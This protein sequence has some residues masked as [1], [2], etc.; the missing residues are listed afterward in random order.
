MSNIVL[1][2]VSKSFGAT[3]VLDEL[4]LAVPDG[5]VVAVLGES[6]SGKTTLLRLVAGFERPGGGT[7]VIGDDVVDAQRLFVPPERRGIGYVAQEGALFPHLSVAKN[8]AFGLARAE[9]K[10]SRVDELLELVGMSGLGSRYPHELSGGQQQ[11]VALARALAPHPRVVLLDEPFSALDAGLRASLRAEVIQILRSTGITTVLVT[12]DQ[13]EA[14]SVSDLVGV[15]ARGKI[16]QLATPGA[17]YASPADA[18]L[19]GFLGEANLVV[20][21]ATN[22]RATT[23]FGEMELG[24]GAASL[25]GTVI[26]LI[27]P[28]QLALRAAARPGEAGPNEV[29]GRVIHREYYGHDSVLLVEVGSEH[30]PV[31]VR[32]AGSSPVEVGDSVLLGASG[33]TVAWP[34]A[35]EMRA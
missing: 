25:E 27:R 14:L 12:H 13:E 1:A 22:G 20:G 8:I 2:G 35:E 5:S 10:S 11:R 30:A 6:G 9:R 23:R 3:R 34:S 28:E 7:I 33:Q 18:E 19:A 29:E 16:R 31:R 26:V 15:M 24:H 4:D 32:C 17:L 21:S